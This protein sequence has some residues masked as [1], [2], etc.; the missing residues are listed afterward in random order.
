MLIFRVPHTL[1]LFKESYYTFRL[2]I[3][4]MTVSRVCISNTTPTT[5]VQIFLPQGLLFSLTHHPTESFVSSPILLSLDLCCYLI[6]YLSVPYMREII[7][8]WSLLFWLTL[9][10][11]ISSSFIYVTA[12][13]MIL[14][15]IEIYI[16]LPK[17]GTFNSLP[18]WWQGILT[19]VAWIISLISEF[20]HFIYYYFIII[21][22]ILFIH[23]TFIAFLETIIELKFVG[24]LYFGGRYILLLAAM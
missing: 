9:H 22:N 14:Y 24:E 5:S 21:I 7:L 23:S 2:A 4:L 15:N 20:I 17:R 18:R 6:L 10:S 19:I 13:S 12:N 8:Y 16:I 1:L 3:L 11:M